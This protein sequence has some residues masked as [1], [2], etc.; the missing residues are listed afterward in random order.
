M[1]R[2]TF[3]R[4]SYK[5]FL[6]RKVIQTKATLIKEDCYDNEYTNCLI[7]QPEHFLHQAGIR[8]YRENKSFKFRGN[9]A[10]GSE[11]SKRKYCSDNNAKA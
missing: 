11:W 4:Y 10:Q 3:V 5:L 7:T 2:K 8:I 6:P 9:R 1:R